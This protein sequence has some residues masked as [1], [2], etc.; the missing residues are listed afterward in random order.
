[1]YTWT[2]AAHGSPDEALQRGNLCHGLARF[3]QGIAQEFWGSRNHFTLCATIPGRH[4]YCATI[5]H[6]APDLP[7]ET[8][9]VRDVIPHPRRPE[10]RA[11][12][13]AL[14]RITLPVA[15]RRSVAGEGEPAAGHRD[16]DLNDHFSITTGGNRRA[17][18]R[19]CSGRK[20]SPSGGTGSRGYRPIHAS[21]SGLRS[22]RSFS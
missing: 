11:R 14:Q 17:A 22:G 1:M 16:T 21:S 15:P 6:P 18:V 10:R 20:T 3:A 19:L 2:G 7:D 4:D 12:G 8:A 13:A 9:T 5:S